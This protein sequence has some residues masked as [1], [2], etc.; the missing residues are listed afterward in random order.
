MRLWLLLLSSAFAFHIEM[1]VSDATP[2]AYSSLLSL[3]PPHHFQAFSF[4]TRSIHQQFFPDTSSPDVILDYTYSKAISSQLLE[5]KDESLVIGMYRDCPEIETRTHLTPLKYAV[6]IADYLLALNLTKAFLVS[7]STPFYIKVAKYLQESPLIH[8]TDSAVIDPDSTSA[9]IEHIIGRLFKPAGSR[10]GVFLVNNQISR[11][12]VTSLTNYHLWEQGYAYVFSEEAGWIDNTLGLL[13]VTEAEG[14][15]VASREEYEAAILNLQL[16]ALSHIQ[17]FGN[18][19]ENREFKQDLTEILEGMARKSKLV[20]MNTQ[21][22]S[23]FVVNSSKFLAGGIIFPGNTTNSPKFTKPALHVSVDYKGQNS[24]GSYFPLG[25]IVMRAYALALEQANLQKDLLPNYVIVN[26]SLS[27]GGFMFNETWATQRIINQRDQLGLAFFPFG[28]DFTSEGVNRVFRKLGISIP[29][30]SLANTPELADISQS[31]LFYT[32]RSSPAELA[33]STARFFHVFGWK[34]LAFISSEGSEDFHFYEVFMNVSAQYNIEIVNNINNRVVPYELEN[35]D[36][37]LNETLQ[38]IFDSS[39]RIVFIAHPRSGTIVERMY[40]LGARAGDYL[41]CLYYALSYA[42]YS[43]DDISTWKRR[44]VI[45]GAMMF[46]ERYFMG[47]EGERVRKLLIEADGLYYENLGCPEYDSVMLLL[48]ALNFMLITGLHYEHGEAL[49][50]EIRNSRITGCLGAVQLAKGSNQRLSGDYSILNA[51]YDEG[52]DTLVLEEVAVYSPTRVQMYN[53]SSDI[54]FPDGSSYGFLDSWPMD[55]NCPY[56]VKNIKDFLGGKMLGLSV[57][58]CFTFFT[59]I[60]AVLIWRLWWKVQYPMLTSKLSMSLEDGLVLLILPVEVC[61][62]LALAPYNPIEP[63]IRYL[64]SMISF[65]WDSFVKP[66]QGAFWG[67][68]IFAFILLFVYIFLSILKFIRIDGVLEKRKMCLST[69]YVMKFLL[70]NLSN[71]LF[72]PTFS[73]LLSNFF[74]SRSTGDNF[75]DSFF[76]L[77]CSE[78]CWTGNHLKYTIIAAI[79]LLIYTPASLVTRPIWQE[80]LSDLHVKIMPLSLIVKSAYQVFLVAI[81]KSLRANFQVYHAIC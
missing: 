68:E 57:C 9:Q 21:E 40:D 25:N 78:K 58:T 77:D 48:Q 20:L 32:T 70:S 1:L 53:I 67:V 79:L 18:T 43:G 71:L 47:K 30:S 39:V 44:N 5:R 27:F 16:V 35:A 17:S 80:L 34:K 51:K 55:S 28:Y 63:Y 23:H 3:L 49:M 2:F 69:I 10:I 19:A 81:A 29:T 73:I 12:I 72:L 50:H 65:T 36:K 13:Y 76:D 6:Q 60:S 61:Q 4:T 54:M 22:K 33:L 56:F 24:D 41:I 26:N 66:T 59:L 75:T 74:C 7:E 8:F 62:L 64:L 45:K 15:Q 11:E 37:Q 14:V 46:H 31:P 42:A 52:N 38:E